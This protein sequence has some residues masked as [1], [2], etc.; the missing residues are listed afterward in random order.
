MQEL[1]GSTIQYADIRYATN[2]IEVYGQ[3]GHSP[4][5]GET[6]ETENGNTNSN[7]TV[8]QAQEIG[9]LLQ[10]DQ[11]TISVAGYLENINDVD[12][13][14]MSVDLGG[15]QSIPGISNL[16]SVW[17]TIFDIDY[18]DQMARADLNLW[19]FDSNR[20]LILAGGESNIT[21]DRPEPIPNA[22]IEDLSRG[23]VGARDPFIG[24][25][26]LQEG[27]GVVYYIAVTSTLNIPN[28]LDPVVSPL[29]RREPIQSVN[30]VATEHFDDLPLQPGQ[31]QRPGL[32][33]CS[34]RSSPL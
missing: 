5:L 30:R 23:S 19:V 11:N 25:A 27:D 12:W 32:L 20:N 29:T 22:T 18:A 14:A 2:G 34:P 6:A 28:E 26:L 8:G 1:P 21:D 9:N 31:H 7:D 10:V 3:P 16:G 15:V 17:A 24:T 13:Y 4:L 33:W